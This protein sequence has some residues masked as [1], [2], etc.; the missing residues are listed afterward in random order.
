[1]RIWAHSNGLCA[2]IHL[3][4][5]SV[6]VLKREGTEDSS[7]ALLSSPDKKLRGC[8]S[9]NHSLIE[10]IFENIIVCPDKTS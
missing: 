9:S 8:F 5:G 7:P 4:Q 10:R 2:V 6:E 1:V 3:I